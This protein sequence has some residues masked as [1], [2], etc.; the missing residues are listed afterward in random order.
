MSTRYYG[1]QNEV[2]AYCNRLQNE[3]SI[4]VTPSVLKTLNDRVESLKRSGIWSQFGL[5]FN[6]NDGDAYLS[7]ASVTDVI[8][9]AEVLWFTRGIKTL[10]LWNNMVAWPLRSY[11]NV[12]SG[13]TVRSLG[14]LGT[15][16]G[17]MVNSP[18]QGTN[19][20]T[21]ASASSQYIT[22][23][24][25]LA[26]N[27]LG[28]VSVFARGSLTGAT[29]VA[30]GWDIPTARQIAILDANNSFVGTQAFTTSG[31]NSILGDPVGTTGLWGAAISSYELNTG[32]RQVLWRNSSLGSSPT[33]AT[34]ST[35]ASA[36]IVSGGTSTFGI[37]ARGGTGG[38]PYNGSIAFSL[39]SNVVL[40]GLEFAIYSLYRSTLGNGLGLP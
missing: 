37:G 25:P 24:L 6:D 5:G 12:G 35:F 21:F 32:L 34:S 11:Q 4:V 28:M 7:R 3:T 36:P 38:N 13:S 20:M 8:G 29:N 33:T 1:V 40:T 19:G 18:S 14:G 2:K 10:G 22:I 31:N 16:D 9:R 27:T 39:A 26:T 15:F 17:N 30:L 23:P